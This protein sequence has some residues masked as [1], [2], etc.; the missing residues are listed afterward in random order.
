MTDL[1]TDTEIAFFLISVYPVNSI[2]RLVLLKRRN[3][4]LKLEHLSLPIQKAKWPI[5]FDLYTK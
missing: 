2:Q 4:F 3:Q 1:L 5:A